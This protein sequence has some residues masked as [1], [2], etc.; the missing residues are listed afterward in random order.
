MCGCAGPLVAFGVSAAYY[1][2]FIYY[3]S[4]ALKKNK[5]FTW[6]DGNAGG[7]SGLSSG[8]FI[9]HLLDHFGRRADESD[10]RIDHLPGEV[11]PLREETVAGMNRVHIVFLEK[12]IV[13]SRY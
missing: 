11:G 6:Y 5:G 13:L 10:A 1:N 7:D 3:S 8:D 12:E 9:A 4:I 2:V